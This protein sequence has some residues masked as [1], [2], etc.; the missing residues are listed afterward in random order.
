MSNPIHR[1]TFLVLLGLCALGTPARGETPPS[2]EAST[3]FEEGQ[4]QFDARNYLAA[5]QAFERAYQLRPHFFVKCSIARCYESLNDPIK[6]AGYYRQCL[7]EGAEAD[8]MA[9][10]V[11][12]SLAEAEARIAHAKVSSGRDGDAIFVDGV[13]AGKTPARIPLNPGAHVVE[14]RR[15]QAAPVR[16]SLNMA[17]GEER[18][19]VLTPLEAQPQAKAEPPRPRPSRRRLSSVWFWSA[20]GATAVLATITII[21]GATTASLAS[22]YNDH[23]TKEGLDRF[24]ERKLWTNVMFGLTAASAAT[25]TTLFFFTDFSRRSRDRREAVAG[26][27]L[28]WRF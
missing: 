22:D 8:P 1:S 20:A 17:R 21:L 5:V 7:K 27:A 25:G 6:A 28:G 11:R 2:G 18:S 13:E 19:V 3:F 15:G 12:V 9:T 24:R 4:R 10:R 23:P 16:T 14:V 26:L